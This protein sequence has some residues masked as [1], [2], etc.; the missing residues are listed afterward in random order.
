MS[1]RTSVSFYVKETVSSNEN[2]LERW[3]IFC[4]WNK[5]DIY[6]RESLSTQTK[7]TRTRPNFKLWTCR[8]KFSSFAKFWLEIYI[9]FFCSLLHSRFH[10]IYKEKRL[11][12]Y[13]KLHICITYSLTLLY[14]YIVHY[15]NK[16]I[17][18]EIH[19]LPFSS[20]KF[21]MASCRLLRKVRQNLSP[22]D[23]KSISWCLCWK[24]SHHSCPSCCIVTR[25]LAQ[26]QFWTQK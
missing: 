25:K 18:P 2:Y 5:L 9:Y 3:H 16:A 22:F 13:C 15:T 10:Y 4:T 20:S 23:T 24:S 14:T 12:T 8:R 11:H 21:L 1:Q 6:T 7:M 19:C 26:C 17:L